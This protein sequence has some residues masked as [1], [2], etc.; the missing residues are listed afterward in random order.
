MR[1]ANLQANVAQRGTDA[2]LTQCFKMLSS[3]PAAL[4]VREGYLLAAAAD[5]VVW[6]AKRPSE[7]VAAF[8]L[9]LFGVKRC[10]RPSPERCRCWVDLE[11]R[12]EG[13]W[14]LSAQKPAE[15]HVLPRHGSLSACNQPE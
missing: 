5:L 1:M 14:H 15:A 12:G 10:W 8:T 6:D 2:D 9:A 4:L 7:A 11:V 3:H 13:V